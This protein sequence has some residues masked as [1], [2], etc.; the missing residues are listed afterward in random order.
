VVW[1][2][3]SVGDEIVIEVDVSN[4]MQLVIGRIPVDAAPMVAAWRQTG[5]SQ[6]YEK[7][8]DRLFAA[9]QTQPS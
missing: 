5:R 4:E 8:L 7:E 9:M 1:A 3:H 6:Y 2:V